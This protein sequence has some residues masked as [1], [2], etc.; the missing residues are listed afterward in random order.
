MHIMENLLSHEKNKLLT[1]L[2]MTL[3]NAD[4]TERIQTKDAYSYC[5]VPFLEAQEAR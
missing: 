4:T 3:K 1:H 5:T 2:T